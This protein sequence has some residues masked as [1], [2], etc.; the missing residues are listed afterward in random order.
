M[1]L[2]FCFSIISV[3]LVLIAGLYSLLMTKNLIR[4]LISIEILMK[5]VTLFIIVTGYIINRPAL[6][7]SMVITT[8]V[9]EVVTVATAAGIAAALSKHYNTL[10]IRK[11]RKLK[12]QE[13]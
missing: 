10:N 2:F 8:T 3:V 6:A 7:Q 4:V 1:N 12:D 5:S 11:I 9:I 13:E